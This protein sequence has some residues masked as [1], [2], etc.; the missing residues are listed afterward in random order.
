MG[1]VVG[2]VV[3]AVAIGAG[4]DGCGA[5]A[6]EECFELAR[7]LAIRTGLVAGIATMVML[8]LV[9]GLLKMVA[10]DEARRTEPASPW[11]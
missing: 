6:R 8:L 5:S 2:L 1:A 10:H 4:N 7:M 3:A 11:D 9:A